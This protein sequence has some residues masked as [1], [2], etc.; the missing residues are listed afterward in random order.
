MSG[1]CGLL[2]LDGRPVAKDEILA[3]TSLLERRGPE[4]TETWC[5]GE[6]GLGHTL[7]ATTPEAAQERLPLRHAA[8]GC[9]ITADV[10]LDNRDELLRR[11]ALHAPVTVGDGEIILA[12][13]LAWGESCVDHLLG[14]FAF[15]IWDPRHLSLFCARDQ[16]GMKQFI[17]HLNPHGFFAFASDPKAIVVL[18]QVPYRINEG[19]IADFL[20]GLEA[21]DFDSTMFEGVFRLPP[22][23]ALTVGQGGLRQRRYWALEPDDELRLPSDKHYEEAF[24]DAFIPAVDRRLRG[25]PSVGAM[26]SGGM[27]SGSVVAVA[28]ELL[29]DRGMGPLTTVSAV[30]P[31]GGSCIETRAIR[32]SLSVEGLRPRL[33]SHDRLDRVPDLARLTSHVDEPADAHMTMVRAVYLEGRDANC[34]AVLDGGGGDVVLNEADF[35]TRLLRRGR[36]VK[37]HRE[38]MCR[39][40]FYGLPF[41]LWR[42]YG[43][44]LRSVVT[45]QTVRDLRRAWHAR[46]QKYE[47]PANHPLRPDFARQV[48]LEERLATVRE[49]TAPAVKAS[50]AARRRASIEHLFFT[51]GRERYDRVASA[52]GIEPRDP[53]TDLQFVRFAARLPGDQLLRD[54]WPK[55]ILRRAMAGRL[56]ESVRYRRGKEHLGWVFTDTLHVQGRMVT[57]PSLNH[58]SDILA[59]YVDLAQVSWHDANSREL[60]YDLMSLGS[61][62]RDHQ[63]RPAARD[64]N[65]SQPD[66]TGRSSHDH[67]E[68]GP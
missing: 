55:A 51:L 28:S 59:R 65:Q 14:D 47:V 17:Y 18:P 63:R 25:A 52:V 56:P 4:G 3:M 29:A 1:I 45:P 20:T 38:L 53:F 15:A 49:R 48:A 44:L 46:R 54:G 62:L 31:S 35:L 12:A 6:L 57:K 19:R 58:P 16:M 43:R 60:H 8:S 9:V 66:S 5:D 21:I 13:Y 61:W 33:V 11:L 40:K 39:S 64:A 22:A 50:Y 37:A 32:E 10:R 23:H 30:S 36:F 27:D 67:R 68:A 7:L 24:L 41:S 2:N 26:L 34:V 42:D